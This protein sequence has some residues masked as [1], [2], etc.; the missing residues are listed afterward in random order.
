MIAAA[1]F[2]LTVLRYDYWSLRC[3][4]ECRRRRCGAVARYWVTFDWVGDLP[5]A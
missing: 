3:C 2:L 1:K 4:R 5:R